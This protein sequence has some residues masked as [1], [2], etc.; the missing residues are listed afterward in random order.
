MV[1]NIFE[2]HVLGTWQAHVSPCIS[3]AIE[4]VQVALETTDQGVWGAQQGQ[5]I[6]FSVV[7]TSSPHPP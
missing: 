1:K 4:V 2:L 6:L 5:C 3:S 7:F